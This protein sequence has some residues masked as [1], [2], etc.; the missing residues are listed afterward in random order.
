M[1]KKGEEKKEKKDKK[2]Y[3][4]IIILASNLTSPEQCLK[5]TKN[6]EYYLEMEY[7]N[8]LKKFYLVCKLKILEGV[9]GIGR[10]RFG[11]IS[12]NSEKSPKI[13]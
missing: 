10:H 11:R 13:S 6:I 3:L 4:I 2:N 9:A 1:E 12:I 5:I 8:D 7:E